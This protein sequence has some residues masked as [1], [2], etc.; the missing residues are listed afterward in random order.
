MGALQIANV[1]VRDFVRFQKHAR[2]A[3]SHLCVYVEPNS[4][5]PEC[6]NKRYAGE[7]NKDH[8]GRM[9]HRSA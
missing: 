9:D 7:E 1:M 5:I 4:L 3:G 8:G 6:F 2:F